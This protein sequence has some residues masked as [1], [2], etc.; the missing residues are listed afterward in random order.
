MVDGATVKLSVETGD[1]ALDLR[2]PVG[3]RFELSG[4]IDVGGLGSRQD[5]GAGIAYGLDPMGVNPLWRTM[6]IVPSKNAATLQYRGERSAML[7]ISPEGSRHEFTL[8]VW[9]DEAVVLVDGQQVFAGPA[10]DGMGRRD[11]AM[12]ALVTQGAQEG[13]S[14]VFSE[15]RVT[16]LSQ[17][18][19][20]LA[21]PARNPFKLDGSGLSVKSSVPGRK[22]PAAE[23][24][25]PPKVPGKTGTKSKPKPTTYRRP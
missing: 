17:P 25:R 21:R 2:A 18:P 22:I 24:P 8:K 9:E 6:L 15:L 20:E 10:P 23:P 3:R 11:G 19:S 7:P 14:A 4:A 1:G 13:D 12:L 16:R 5:A